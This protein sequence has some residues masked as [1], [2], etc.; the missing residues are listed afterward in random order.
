MNLLNN[1]QTE[2]QGLLDISSEEALALLDLC[3]TSSAAYDEKANRVV[4]N[5]AEFCSLR[6]FVERTASRA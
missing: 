4:R 1:S 3:L 6:E 2:Q 5:L